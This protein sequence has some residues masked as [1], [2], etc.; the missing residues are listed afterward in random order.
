M[1]AEGGHAPDHLTFFRRWAGEAR[2]FSFFAL[3]RQAEAHARGLP[4]IG[5]SRLPQHNVADLAHSTTLDFP[6]STVE[7]IEF[8]QTG[9]ARVR[10][11]FLGLTGPMGALPLHLTEFAHY[12]QRYAPKRPFGR[13]LDLLTDRMLQ[14]FYR[15]WAD[16]QPAVHADR[17]DEDRFAGYVASV[18]GINR[19]ERQDFPH[20]ARLHFAGLFASRRNPAVLS[21]CLTSLLH[22][23]VSIREFVPRWRE[24]VR[25]DRTRIGRGGA[26]NRLGGQAV[27]GKAVRTIDD[28]FRVQVRCTDWVEYLRFLPTGRSF[29][30]AR[31]VLGAL[32]PPH[33]EWR[34]ELGIAES[35]IQGATL[36]GRVPL[37][38]AAWIA[39][40]GSQ[41]IRADARLGRNAALRRTSRGVT[42]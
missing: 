10:T 42:I 31:D 5:R 8:T 12:E 25:S 19:D 22:V 40:K 41:S 16:T 7:S 6:G 29:A 1:A 21:D 34:L 2:R 17:Q 15:S 3:L 24:I 30:V 33:L 39:P 28:T 32:A 11:L 27:L 4:P 26:F 18:A 36:D 38:W 20:P 23:A 9:R 37:G 14:F 13:F 35:A